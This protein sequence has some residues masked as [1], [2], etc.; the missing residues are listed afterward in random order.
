MSLREEL[1]EAQVLEINLRNGTTPVNEASLKHLCE[2][3]SSLFALAASLAAT[4]GGFGSSQRKLLTEVATC[5]GMA[6]QLMDD[7]LDA[8]AQLGL[9]RDEVSFVTR[10][11]FDRSKRFL[12]ELSVKTEQILSSM[13]RERNALALLTNKI[14]TPPKA[15]GHQSSVFS[16]VRS[17]GTDYYVRR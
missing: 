9:A 13:L 15:D 6:Y 11:G 17:D 7:I 2:L 14:L 10:F 1:I 5:L 4:L 8:Q 12:Q 16:A 3:K